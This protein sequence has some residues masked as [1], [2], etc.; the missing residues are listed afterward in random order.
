MSDSD[1]HAEIKKYRDTF[2]QLQ[3]ASLS[4]KW[5]T[6]HTRIRASVWS[7]N[8]VAPAILFC[9]RML[10]ENG[11]VTDHQQIITPTTDRL[12]LDTD[13]RPGLGYLLNCFF[14][15]EVLTVRRGSVYARAVLRNAKDDNTTDY[16]CQGYVTSQSSPQW[17]D[18]Y[19]EASVSGQGR[20]N[21]VTGTDPAA[22]ANFS[23]T[24][25]TN[26]RWHLRGLAVQLITAVAAAT[27][28]V[29]IVID[30]G[31]TEIFRFDS[32]STQLASLTRDYRAADYKLQPADN[33]TFIYIAIPFDFELLQGYRIR[34][35]VE[36][37]QAADD[38]GAPILAIEEWLEE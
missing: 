20:I 9:Y 14:T 6:E 38:F 8:G 7:A 12:V 19:N 10:E 2:R 22:G 18:G 4:G 32:Q 26:A 11:S 16:L 27:R 24:V 1:P 23:E 37:L 5:M 31:T 30:D 33:G 17:P 34:S 15:T 21:T 36:N 35:V 28:R 13:I 25:P 3:K 29:V